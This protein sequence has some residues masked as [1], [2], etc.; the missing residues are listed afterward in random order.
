LSWVGAN[1]VVKLLFELGHFHS[2]LF[3]YDRDNGDLLWEMD[4]PANIH[5]APMTYTAHDR[6][7]IVVAIGGVTVPAELV[8]LAV[9]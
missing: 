1:S 3:A 7:Y 2:K 9:R 5:G 8:A 4:M 6:Q